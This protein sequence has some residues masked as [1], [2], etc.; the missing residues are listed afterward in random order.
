ML[1][2]IAA[3]DAVRFQL[4]SNS[5]AVRQGPVRRGSSESIL[6]RNF[7]RGGRR[8]C[9]SGGSRVSLSC[10]LRLMRSVSAMLIVPVQRSLRSSFTSSTVDVSGDVT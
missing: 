3:V 5:S 2:G 1:C 4:Y 6:T 9:G 10:C 8:L 7:R